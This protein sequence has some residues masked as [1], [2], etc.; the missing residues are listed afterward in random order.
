MT[1]KY[2]FFNKTKTA[3]SITLHEN[4]RIIRIIKDGTKISHT[5]NK[6]FTN[7]TKTLK[8]KKISP[9]PKKPLKHLLKHLGSAQGILI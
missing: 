7:L 1:V 5:L 4:H 3:N 2:L 8:L 6:Y 9:P